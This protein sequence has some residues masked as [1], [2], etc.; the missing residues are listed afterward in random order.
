MGG[1]F[2]CGLGSSLALL[3]FTISRCRKIT[4]RCKR[5]SITTRLVQVQD[6]IISR[7]IIARVVIYG[8][9]MLLIGF[10]SFCINLP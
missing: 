8:A 3:Y 9:T 5:R 6:Y 2:R 10:L 7:F 1:S 4:H